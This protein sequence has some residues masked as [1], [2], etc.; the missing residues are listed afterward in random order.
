MTLRLQLSDASSNLPTWFGDWE[1]DF[2]YFGN[3]NFN[4]SLGSAGQ[5]YAGGDPTYSPD[6]HNGESSVILNGTDFDYNQPGDFSGHPLSLELGKNLWQDLDHD[7][8]KQDTALT[9][10]VDGGGDLPIT[11]AFRYAIY[12]LS[13]GGQ[14]EGYQPPSGPAFLGLTDYFAEQGTVQEGTPGNDTFLGFDGHDTFVFENGGGVDHVANFDVAQDVLDVSDWGVTDLSG[15][16]IT[17]FGG[18]TLISTTDFSN[19]AV[20]DAETPTLTSTNFNFAPAPALIP[21][22]A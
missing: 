14:Y 8:F 1:T 11:D 10:T 15:L 2:D 19:S 9:I 22:L 18:D 17:P 20:L 13:H 12:G 16:I 4:G 21:E 7:L 6:D 5:F 3:G